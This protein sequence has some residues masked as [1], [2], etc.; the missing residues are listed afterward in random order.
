MNTIVI[1]CGC[2][3]KKCST[4]L[5]IEVDEENKN[6]MRLII[7]DEI[8]Q[9]ASWISLDDKGL[10]DLVKGIHKRKGRLEER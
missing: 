7:K 4:E 1:P 5:V 2:G 10:A 9:Y 8:H 3:S 6:N